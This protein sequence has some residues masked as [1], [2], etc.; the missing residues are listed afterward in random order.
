[1]SVYLSHATSFCRGVWDP[2]IERLTDH[3]CV[4]WDFRGHG[5]A[6]PASFPVEWSQFGEQVLE[7]TERGGVGVGHSMG[8]TALLMAE[9]ADPGRFTFLVLIEPSVFPGP[10]HRAD[11]AMSVVAL[12]RKTSFESR[13]AA[14]A[15]FEGRGA[16]E[17]WDPAALDGYLRCG[18][19]GDRPVELACSA[20]TEADVYRA[21]NTHDTWDRLDEIEAP[22]LILAGEM[23]DTT[24][25]D[26][27]RSQAARFVRAGLEIVPSAGHFLPMQLPEIVAERVRR[28]ATL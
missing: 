25:P 14:R 3:D 18:L 22:V 26:F 13:E 23:S 7:E 10:R 16:F 28:V 12:K 5:G 27:A 24:P 20:E 6:P 4:A 17:G 2:V 11:N 9:L 19:K 1:M 21:Y 8:A 15:N